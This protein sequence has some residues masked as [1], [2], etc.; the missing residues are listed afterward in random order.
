ML[1]KS[2][3]CLSSVVAI[4]RQVVPNSWTSSSKRSVTK[5]TVAARY[6]AVRLMNELNDDDSTKLIWLN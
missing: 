3:D 2:F 5:R 1:A 4:G 6:E